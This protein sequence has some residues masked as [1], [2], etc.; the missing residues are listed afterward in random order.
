MNAD[1][2]SQTPEFSALPKFALRTRKQ[3]VAGGTRQP[4]R[5][6]AGRRTAIVIRSWETYE[7]TPEDL[8]HLRSITTEAA[9]ST[10]SDYAV[11]LLVDIK[12]TSQEIH[13]DPAAYAT[14]LK[15]CV[16]PELQDIAVLFDKTLLESWYPGVPDHRYVLVLS[17]QE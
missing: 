7:Y 8:W 2:F 15:N 6:R 14:A 16:P 17:L 4:A 9:L 5:G 10:S 1:R 12:D 11:Y 13:K 3:H